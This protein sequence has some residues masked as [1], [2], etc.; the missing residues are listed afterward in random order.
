MSVVTSRATLSDAAEMAAHMRPEDVAEVWAEGRRTPYEALEMSL[1]LSGSQAWTVRHD[2]KILAMWGAAPIDLISGV[3]V[4]WLLT[5]DEVDRHPR[6]F[7]RATREAVRWLRDKYSISVNRID[8]RYLRA[9]RWAR[10]AGF[11]V[12]EAM[13]LDG[14]TFHPITLRGG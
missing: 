9:V 10:R 1:S 13:T 8:A 4:V 5:T 14:Y 11:E 2:G 3:A 6:S 12:G 7:M